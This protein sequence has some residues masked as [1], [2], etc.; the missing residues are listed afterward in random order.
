MGFSD[1]DP[2]KQKK[3]DELKKKYLKK[4]KTETPEK[5]I[6]PESYDDKGA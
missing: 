5:Q 1:L 2:E 4:P 3:Y 6:Q